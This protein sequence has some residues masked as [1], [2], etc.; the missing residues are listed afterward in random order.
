MCLIPIFS[1][2]VTHKQQI[3][4]AAS[5]PNP[6]AG[7]RACHWQTR[8]DVAKQAHLTSLTPVWQDVIDSATPHHSDR[9][10]QTMSQEAGRVHTAQPESAASAKCRETREH[11]TG[12]STHTSANHPPG[13]QWA[14][15]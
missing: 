5:V 1:C 15:A 8:C 12:G 6:S 3:I 14:E 7:F 10:D 4:F 2:S 11:T 9:H 13:R